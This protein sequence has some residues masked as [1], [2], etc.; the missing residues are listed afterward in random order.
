M[1]KVPPLR[2]NRSQNLTAK[3]RAHATRVKQEFLEIGFY[4]KRYKKKNLQYFIE[5]TIGRCASYILVTAK[6]SLFI[7]KEE[8][9]KVQ[10]KRYKKELEVTKLKARLTQ[11]EVKLLQ[12]KN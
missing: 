8:Q 5:I 7:S 9:E 10:R 12:V 11:S 6:C 1:P 4:Y 2:R 3:R